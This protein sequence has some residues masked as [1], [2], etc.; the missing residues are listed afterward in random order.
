[1]G[2]TCCMGAIC[3]MGATCGMAAD[4]IAW[5]CMTAGLICAG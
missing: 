2:A 1:M 3:C 5:G 4:I